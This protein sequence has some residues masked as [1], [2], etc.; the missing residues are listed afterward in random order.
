MDAGEALGH[1]ELKGC[2]MPEGAF[3]LLVSS[4]DGSLKCSRALGVNYTGGLD[5]G[6]EPGRYLQYNE[7]CTLIRS[8]C[9][10]MAWGGSGGGL[11]PQETFSLMPIL[12]EPTVHRLFAVADP[13]PLPLDD[14]YDLNAGFN[15]LLLFTNT[16]RCSISP[17]IAICDTKILTHV[18]SFGLWCGVYVS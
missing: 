18:T 12:Y 2:W 3:L 4:N 8:T 6:S 10:P 7:V 11:S 5:D 13:S 15:L 16:S 1:E 14:Q 17:T 9:S